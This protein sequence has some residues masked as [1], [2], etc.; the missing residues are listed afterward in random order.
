MIFSEL[1]DREFI[2][3]ANENMEILNHSLRKIDPSMLRMHVFGEI[4]KVPIL[5]IFQ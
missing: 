1:S 4:M 3:I 5:M 2:K